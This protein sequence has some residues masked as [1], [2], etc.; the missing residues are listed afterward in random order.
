MPDRNRN[1]DKSPKGQ[2]YRNEYQKSH[3]TRI[4]VLAPPDLAD[5]IAA[6]AEA[7]GL[8]KTQFILTAVRAYMEKG[9][10]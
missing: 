8:T 5:D 3:Y 1:Y 4:V 7:A 2:A 6:A 9:T 10:E